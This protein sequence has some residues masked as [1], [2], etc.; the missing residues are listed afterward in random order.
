VRVPAGSRLKFEI[1]S[2]GATTYFLDD[3][4]IDGPYTGRIEISPAILTEDLLEFQL[5]AYI[6][7]SYGGTCDIDGVQVEVSSTSNVATTYFDGDT[8]GCYWTGLYYASTS[9]RPATVR[10]GGQIENFDSY[11][12][13]NTTMVD[14][15]M[16]SVSHNIDDYAV[17]DG[18]LYRS[19]RTPSRVFGLTGDLIGTSL[20]DLHDKRRA[21][22]NLFKND[23]TGKN[24]PFWLRYTGGGETMQIQ[25]RYDSGLGGQRSGRN[26]FTETLG[27]RFIAEDP[28]W[29]RDYT[30]GVALTARKTISTLSPQILAR[31][32][33]EWDEFDSSTKPKSGVNV[34]V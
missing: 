30:V 31:I 33:G 6:P 26:G 4:T 16:A 18:A 32:D 12:F 15:G 5:Y 29:Y 7:A 27:L 10:D 1:Y 28:Y 19:S 11:G 2:F 3:I 17:Q 9:V 34:A 13:Y 25:C 21:L 23:V 24:E 8:P 22:I 20:A 14:F